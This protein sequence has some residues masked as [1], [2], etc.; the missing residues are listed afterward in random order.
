MSTKHLG[1]TPS[2]RRL[3]TIHPITAA[4]AN[5]KLTRLPTRD[6]DAD[7]TGT[8]PDT[9][10]RLV[11]SVDDAAYLLNISRGLAYELVARGELPAIRLG[12]RIVIPR[13]ILE[14]LLGTAIR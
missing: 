3:A 12:R 14:E 11:L 4:A 9:A 1:Y 10:E 2:P 6:G 13:I 8:I 7:C 5:R